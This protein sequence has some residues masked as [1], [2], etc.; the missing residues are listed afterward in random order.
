[1]SPGVSAEKALIRFTPTLVLLLACCRPL[2]AEPTTAAPKE[3]GKDRLEEV[4]AAWERSRT[5]ERPLQFQI[6]MKSK[7]NTFDT[8][9]GTYRGKGFVQ[10]GKSFRADLQGATGK[11]YLTLLIVKDTTRLYLFEN[12]KLLIHSAALRAARPGPRSSSWFDSLFAS[13]VE[14]AVWQM[15]GIP[16]ADFRKRFRVEIEKED[17]HGI[18]LHFHPRKQFGSPPDAE[19]QVVLEQETYRPRRVCRQTRSG[20]TAVA[21]FKRMRPAALPEKTWQPPFANC[22]TGWI[23][24]DLRKPFPGEEARPLAKPA[25]R[26]KDREK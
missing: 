9:E 8:D 13:C 16:P 17:A 2:P 26:G 1:M 12:K 23:E 7:D 18:Y 4:L 21:D 10:G 15:C 5:S 20:H 11:P 19:W 24:V 6:T 3:G 22:P 25:G 14:G